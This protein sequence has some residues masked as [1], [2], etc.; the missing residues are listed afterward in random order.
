MRTW[1]RTGCHRPTSSRASEDL[2]DALGPMMP[3]PLPARSTKLTSCTTSFCTPG[4][5]AET[6]STARF[7]TGACSGIRSFCAGNTASSRFSR[8]QP[9]R[10]A[11][12]PFQLAIARSTGASARADRIE[13][14]MM[15]PAEA[16]WLM[17]SQAPTASTPD[18]IIMRRR[19]RDRAEPARHV[20][21]LAMARHVA[22]VGLGPACRRCARSC[23][24]RRSPRRCGWKSRQARCAP[25]HAGSY[26][27]SASWSISPSGR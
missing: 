10:A 7:A 16:C 1:P 15:M 24:S 12:K 23:P 3:S 22:P 13:P 4:G 18:W 2:P 21:R 26:P 17:T 20:A 25:A 27:A 8:A 5:A 19:F 11:W 14:A 9:W 6:F